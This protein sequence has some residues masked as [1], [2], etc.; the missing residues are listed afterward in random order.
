MKVALLNPPPTPPV[1]PPLA[2][3]ALASHLRR[4]GVE[5]LPVDA[6]VEALHFLLAPE[7]VEAGLGR[8]AG[9]AGGWLAGPPGRDLEPWRMTTLL[10]PADRR[11]LA[12]AGADD[13]RET[14]AEAWRPDGFRL[15]RSRYLAQV[16]R[17][18]DALLVSTAPCHPTVVT[19]T[20]CAATAALLADPGLDPYLPYV[21]DAL[22]PRL[23]AWGPDLVG[24]SLGY[25]QQLLPGVALIRAVRAALAC[26][27]VVGGA[28]FTSLCRDAT[29]G[30]DE[31]RA[32]TLDLARSPA[33]GRVLATV[34]APFGIRGEGE[35]ALLELCRA[36][37]DGREVDAVPSLVRP[38]RGAG[39]LLLN[40]LAETL[41]GRE[42]PPLALDGL[43]IGRLYLTPLPAAPALTSRGCYWNRCAFCDHG[44]P[45]GTRFRQAA[46]GTVVETLAGYQR[47]GVSHVY[48]CDEGTSPA[49]LRHLAAAVPAAGVG[50]ALGTMARLER[51]LPGLVGG[52][53][54]AGLRFLSVGLESGCPRVVRAMDKGFTHDTA[55]AVLE[56]CR[57]HGVRVQCHVMFGFPGETRE[58]AAET[59][60]F[61]ERFHDR[62]DFVRACPWVLEPGSPIGRDPGRFG[63]VPSSARPISRDPSSYRLERGLSTAEALAL[64]EELRAH[65]LLGP[66][67]DLEAECF[68]IMDALL[69]R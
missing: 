57:R 33:V 59:I 4:A 41:P 10:H 61:L 53:A 39:R 37:E 32:T 58:E 44:S 51:S 36:L 20:G 2:L 55:V 23:R 9:R 25:K 43:P 3:V 65:P 26:P 12:E 8:A 47:D 5:V 56:E 52:A 31:A 42:L 46:V 62:V 54:A 7:R 68:A 6:S 18:N 16:G 50:V 69:P 19:L 66:K 1:F 24:V 49:M 15:D 35:V 17:L 14:V 40:P 28:L 22:I 13:A 30:A 67:L 45:I 48:L 21:R 29:G 64:V 63:V 38:D 34:L 27:V 11:P 60:R